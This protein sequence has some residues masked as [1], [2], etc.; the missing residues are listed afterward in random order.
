MTGIRLTSQ[1]YNGGYCTAQKLG[2]YRIAIQYC[3]GSNWLTL[4]PPGPNEKPKGVSGR[5]CRDILNK[6]LSRGDGDYLIKPDSSGKAIKVKC[7]MSSFGGGWTMCYT[8]DRHVNIKTELVTK[9]STGY[10]ADCNN[11]P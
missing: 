5:S 2:T 8:T 10:R 9:P 7:D 11:I 3:D 4:Q 6:G 1:T